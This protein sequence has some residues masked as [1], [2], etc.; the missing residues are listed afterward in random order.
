MNEI[1]VC[2]DSARCYSKP[3]GDMI[4]KIS[5]RIGR[6]TKLLDSENIKGFVGDVGLDGHTFCPATFNNVK[7]KK[8]HFEQMQLFVLDFDNDAPDKQITFDGVKERANTYNLD[9]FLH[10]KV[11][12]ARTKTVLE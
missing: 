2:L 5:D 6:Q 11:L 7:R 12:E 1:K 8:E 4:I 10:T 3:E 9:L